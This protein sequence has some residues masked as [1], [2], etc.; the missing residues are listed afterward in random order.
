MK[1]DAW[2]DPLAGWVLRGRGLTVLLRADYRETTA[3]A[4]LRPPQELIDFLERWLCMFPDSLILPQ[5]L[6]TMIAELLR[7]SNHRRDKP[8]HTVAP[9]LRSSPIAVKGETIRNTFTNS[10]KRLLA[11]K[12]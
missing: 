7:V 10:H 3:G 4:W 12:G 6:T 9:P 11:Y 2:R 5:S 8:V 1:R